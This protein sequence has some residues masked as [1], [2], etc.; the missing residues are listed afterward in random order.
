MPVLLFHP[1]FH[2][3]ILAG[4]KRQTIRG[5]VASRGIEPG[6]TI[7]LRAWEA[8]SYRSPQVVIR[9][10]LCLGIHRINMT[11][12]FKSINVRIDSQTLTKDEV[13]DFI[14]A[15]GFASIEDFREHWLK[16]QC[17]HFSGHLIRWAPL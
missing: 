1:R 11:I 6:K 15:D 17:T 8:K 3:P 7:S 2:A 9:E 5:K 16:A 13:E 12:K 4:T 10:V 14:R